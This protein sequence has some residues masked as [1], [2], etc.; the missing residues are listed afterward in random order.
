[1]RLNNNLFILAYYAAVHHTSF[2]SLSPIKFDIV[3]DE[4]G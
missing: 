3:Q 2:R 4:D 1:M